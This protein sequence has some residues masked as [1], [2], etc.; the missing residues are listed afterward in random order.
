M[1]VILIDNQ[2]IKTQIVTNTEKIIDIFHE[3]QL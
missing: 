2:H 1:Q 3:K